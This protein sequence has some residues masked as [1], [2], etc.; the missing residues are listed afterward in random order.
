MSAPDV[1]KQD[2]SSSNQVSPLDDDRDKYWQFLSAVDLEWLRSSIDADEKK[3]RAHVDAI[4]KEWVQYSLSEL[5]RLTRST[6]LFSEHCTSISTVI[7]LLCG[8][9][10][11]S[12]FS[13]F[14][15][16]RAYLFVKVDVIGLNPIY[17]EVVEAGKQGDTIYLDFGCCSQSLFRTSLYRAGELTSITNITSQWALTRENSWQ[18]AIQHRTSLLAIYTRSSL[19]SGIGCT[20]TRPL[21]RSISLPPMLSISHIHLLHWHLVHPTRSQTSRK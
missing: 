19:I 17:K 7:E 3:M 8:L 6:S 18:M 21:S 15:C 12:D 14:P 2:E 13:H 9:H 20:T 11:I 10:P 5:P 16:I 1:D 4:R